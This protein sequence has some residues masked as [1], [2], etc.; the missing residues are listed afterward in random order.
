M[1]RRRRNS[2]PTQKGSFILPTIYPSVFRQ[3]EPLLFS[4]AGL[5]FF[6]LC[7]VGGKNSFLWPLTE[8]GREGGDTPSTTNLEDEV[9]SID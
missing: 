2:S 1:K 3:G 6:F 7:R 9:V 8:M 4:H 5:F